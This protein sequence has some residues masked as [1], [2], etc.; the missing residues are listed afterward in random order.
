[1]CASARDTTLSARSEP[2]P[3]LRLQYVETELKDEFQ[4]T[5]KMRPKFTCNR[6]NLEALFKSIY[7][8]RMT[9]HGAREVSHSA[10]LTLFIRRMYR[11][12]RRFTS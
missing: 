7:S 10:G 12:T 9:Y 3:F 1:M 6:A 8:P 2:D 5:T 4:L 11:L